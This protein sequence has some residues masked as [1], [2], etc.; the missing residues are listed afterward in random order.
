MKNLSVNTSIKQHALLGLFLG[1]WMVVFLVFISPFDAADLSLL[2]RSLLMPPYGFILFLTYLF[3][4]SLQNWWY[5]LQKKW[6]ALYEIVLCVFF[7]ILLILPCFAYYKSPWMNGDYSFTTF[8]STVYLPIS[9]VFIPFVYF[10]RNYLRKLQAKKEKVILK[11]ANKSDILQIAPEKVVCISSA[12]NYVEVLY[13]TDEGLNKTLL[14]KPLKTIAQEMG[15]MVQVHRSY[16][17][18]PQHFVKWKDSKTAIFHNLE[19]PI[20]RNYKSALTNSI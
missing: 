2:N 20:S 16:L 8:I 19:I 11:G 12:Q 14:R 7:C 18:N 1:V 17:V 4:V 9:L 3:I 15:D 13:L 6:T 5:N 10:G